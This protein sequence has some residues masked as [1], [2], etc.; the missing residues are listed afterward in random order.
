MF[1]IKIIYKFFVFMSKASVI[2]Q[3]KQYGMFSNT[4]I[5]KFQTKLKFQFMMFNMY[6]AG[7]SKVGGDISLPRI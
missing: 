2:H 5:F 1:G 6:L 7:V 3:H 4:G